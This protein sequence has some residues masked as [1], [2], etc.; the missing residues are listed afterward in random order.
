MKQNAEAVAG[1]VHGSVSLTAQCLRAYRPWGELSA[2]DARAQARWEG[3]L[4]LDFDRCILLFVRCTTQKSDQGATPA[5]ANPDPEAGEGVAPDG[6]EN[7]PGEKTKPKEVGGPKG[8][9]PT[10]YG[11]WERNG[12]CID[13]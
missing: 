2:F 9:E 1:I 7:T 6:G 4:H 12:R 11:D 5:G 10:R 13:F 3:A 8:P